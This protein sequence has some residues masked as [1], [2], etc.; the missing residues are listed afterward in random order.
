MTQYL[1]WQRKNKQEAVTVIEVGYVHDSHF[2]KPPNQKSNR[3]K[4]L[5]EPNEPRIMATCGLW[6]PRSFSPRRRL[7]NFSSSRRSPFSVIRLDR[8]RV[9]RRVSCSYNNQEN[10][11]D[12]RPQSS[13]IQ[14]YGEIE[15]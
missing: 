15:R 3:K 8:E 14:V 11:R 9:S 12:H 6:T 1:R 5:D 4:S 13:G 7:C 10:D 2:Q